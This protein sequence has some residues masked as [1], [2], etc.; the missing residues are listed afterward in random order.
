VNDLR[1]AF[2][3]VLDNAV[4]HSPD[5]GQI[6]ITARAFEH[7]ILIKIHNDGEA[8]PEADLARIFEMFYRRDTARTTPGLGL[9]LSIARTIIE[10]QHGGH[11][12]AE[13]SSEEGTTIHIRLP[14]FSE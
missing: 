5:N 13:S 12:Y 14:L 8:I 9:G 10:Q 1:G 11:I 6:T 7:V 4:R 2:K 3:H